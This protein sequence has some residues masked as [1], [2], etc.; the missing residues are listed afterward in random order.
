MKKMKI[1]FAKI[2]KPSEKYSTE[3]FLNEEKVKTV[4]SDRTEKHA[5]QLIVTWHSEND[6]FFINKLELSNE[7]DTEE[8]IRGF[9]NESSNKHGNIVQILLLN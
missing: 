4:L 2:V 7:N 5:L 8:N 1:L 3:D 9:L 6:E